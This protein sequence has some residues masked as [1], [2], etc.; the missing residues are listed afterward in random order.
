[1]IHYKYMHFLYSYKLTN[2]PDLLRIQDYSLDR[3]PR[4]LI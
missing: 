1:M 2:F 3:P 4:S